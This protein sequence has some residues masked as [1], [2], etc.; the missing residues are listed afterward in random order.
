MYSDMLSD[1]G[2]HKRQYGAR[3]LEL[4]KKVRISLA[5]LANRTAVSPPKPRPSRIWP[6][7]NAPTEPA[8]GNPPLEIISGHQFTVL[9]E[10]TLRMKV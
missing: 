3:L 9:L 7:L 2:S 4:K 1:T 10:R 6:R 5:L 8:N